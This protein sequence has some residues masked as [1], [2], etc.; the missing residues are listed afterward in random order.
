MRHFTDIHECSI[1]PCVH[2]SCNDGVNNFTCNCTNGYEGT[3]CETGKFSV[4]YI[5]TSFHVHFVDPIMRINLYSFF[6]E[7]SDAF[8]IQRDGLNDLGSTKWLHCFNGT[9]LI[10]VALQYQLSTT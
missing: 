8:Y 1:N 5:A 2:G 7:K 10:F 6:N 3:F 9:K 4:F